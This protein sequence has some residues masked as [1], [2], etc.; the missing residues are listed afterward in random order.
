L[1]VLRNNRI[2]IFN[3]LRKIIIHKNTPIILNH[4]E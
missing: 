3:K 1:I 4:S 2:S